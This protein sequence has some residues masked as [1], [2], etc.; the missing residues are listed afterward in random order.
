MHFSNIYATK[1][2]P[3][4]W[5]EMSKEVTYIGEN[6]F[7]AGRANWK[8]EDSKLW[9]LWSK[10]AS[11]CGRGSEESGESDEV[12]FTCQFGYPFSSTGMQVDNR[13][14]AP[15]DTHLRLSQ[16]T[17]GKGGKKQIQ[18]CMGL[19][20]KWNSQFV[21]CH[22]HPVTEGWKGYANFQLMLDP[23]KM[24]ELW[25][26]LSQTQIGKWEGMIYQK[27]SRETKC[28]T[29]LRNEFLVK[30]WDL[31]K[32]T[33]MLKILIC[34]RQKPLLLQSFFLSFLFLIQKWGSYW[35]K[36]L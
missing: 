34:L 25:P 5:E 15:F 32:I 22:G 23:W 12:P 29:V 10:Y 33:S 4:R 2:L 36:R 27:I 30:L 19:I 8:R 16:F 11:C 24:T 14:M 6:L 31:D 17:V 3:K 9:K 1:L 35:L 28:L 26:S 21:N 7:K 20:T 13:V 18:H